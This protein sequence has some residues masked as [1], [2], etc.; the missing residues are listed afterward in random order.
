VIT[1]VYDNK[2][3]CQVFRKVAQLTQD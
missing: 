1:L 2:F 3:T